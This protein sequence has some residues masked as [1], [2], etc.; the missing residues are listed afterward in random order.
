MPSRHLSEKENILLLPPAHRLP[1]LRE[2]V[3]GKANKSCLG[4]RCPFP[5]TALADMFIFWP[6][7]TK[8]TKNRILS[9]SSVCSLCLPC[10]SRAL[11]SFSGEHPVQSGESFTN[12]CRFSNRATFCSPPPAFLSLFLPNLSS[13]KPDRRNKCCVFTSL[14]MSAL[15][16]QMAE[17]SRLWGTACLPECNGNL[18]CRDSA[19]Y[20]VKQCA[21]W[22]STCRTMSSNGKFLQH[23]IQ[24]YTQPSI[25]EI[26]S[27]PW[28]PFGNNFFTKGLSKNQTVYPSLHQM[29]SLS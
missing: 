6:I 14:A 23:V 21:V 2:S 18:L 3:R 1:C 27:G 12:R 17:S 5:N 22:T 8:T 20:L 26:F 11:L 10:C 7:K 24:G 25:L 4:V 9:Y 16:E 19:F 13:Y 29:R 28:R 15:Q